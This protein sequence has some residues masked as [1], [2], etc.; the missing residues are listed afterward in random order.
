MKEGSKWKRGRER[1]KEE[2]GCVERQEHK[3]RR[4]ERE[5]ESKGGDVIMSSDYQAA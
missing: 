2:K 4:H 5:R 3:G 1:K